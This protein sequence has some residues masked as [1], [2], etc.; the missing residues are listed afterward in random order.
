MKHRQPGEVVSVNGQN[1]P[2]IGLVIGA[3]LSNDK[4]ISYKIALYSKTLNDFSSK[5]YRMYDDCDVQANSEAET[6]FDYSSDI[7]LGNLI[8][9]NVPVEHSSARQFS[10][11]SRVLTVVAIELRNFSRGPKMQLN[12]IGTSSIPAMYNRPSGCY[13]ANE[14]YRQ[15][16]IVYTGVD[17]EGN[18]YYNLLDYDVRLLPSSAI[19]NEV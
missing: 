17:G 19:T 6:Y 11:A 12:Q 2:I 8:E 13:T 7:L 1:G 18:Y 15:P 16:S 3:H 14:K 4:K 10:I 5:S 9:A